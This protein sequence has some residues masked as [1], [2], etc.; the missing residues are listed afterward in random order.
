MCVLSCFAKK[1]KL[2][3]RPTKRLGWTTEPLCRHWTADY[4][5]RPARTRAPEKTLEPCFQY[6]RG[7]RV[8]DRRSKACFATH[9]RVGEEGKAWRDGESFG[10]DEIFYVRVSVICLNWVLNFLQVWLYGWHD[11]WWWVWIYA[12]WRSGCT[13]NAQYRQGHE[14]NRS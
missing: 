1:R 11:I 14:V 6:Q 7:E 2:T 3:V 13:Y 4:Y 8:W 10:M 9:A 12:G 5:P